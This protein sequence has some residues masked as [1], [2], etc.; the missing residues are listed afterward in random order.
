M[1]R[2]TFTV[3]G[4]PERITCQADEDEIWAAFEEAANAYF[5]ARWP[6]DRMKYAPARQRFYAGNS[7]LV[8][9]QDEIKELGEVLGED[10]SQKIPMRAALNALANRES[11]W[12]RRYRE[13]LQA[14]AAAQVPLAG[15][16]KE[17]EALQDAE[18]NKVPPSHR[19]TGW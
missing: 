3:E 16:L 13:L 11:P 17:I 7:I 8:I 15:A 14:L 19:L 2:T 9:S 5:F 10:M 1:K 12:A 4:L 18:E 6:A